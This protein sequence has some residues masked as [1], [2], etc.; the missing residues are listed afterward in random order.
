MLQS[1]W[2]WNCNKKSVSRQYHFPRAREMHDLAAVAKFVRAPHLKKKKGTHV[3]LTKLRRDYWL[4]PAQLADKS[5]LI[6][7]SSL[8]A[9]LASSAMMEPT[10]QPAW[11]RRAAFFQSHDERNF[12]LNSIIFSTGADDSSAMPMQWPPTSKI[13]MT[14]FWRT[15]FVP[16]V[17]LLVS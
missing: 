4:F 13:F 10:P 14:C 8:E 15:R 16:C 9:A 3:L 12:F 17:M 5:R 11:S 1:H 6:Y 2:H 7:G